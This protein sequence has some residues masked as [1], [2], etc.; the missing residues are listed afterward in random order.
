MAVVKNGGKTKYNKWRRTH[1]LDLPKKDYVS[2]AVLAFYVHLK[3][4]K[5]EDTNFKLA[6]KVAARAFESLSALSD[7]SSCPPKKSHASGGG[8]TIFNYFVNVR[9]SLKG[10]FPERLLRIK[11]KELYCDWLRENPLSENEKPLKF[12][13]QWIKD[14]EFEFN[15]SLR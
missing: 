4:W 8:R 14:W 2:Q 15:I 10:R 11:A 9:I 3:D 12:G 7:T 6:C 5:F 13:D 1:V